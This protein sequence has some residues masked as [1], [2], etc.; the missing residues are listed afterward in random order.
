MNAFSNLA[1]LIS[2]KVLFLIIAFIIIIVLYTAIR[3][4]E[5]ALVGDAVQL[6]LGDPA[7]KLVGDAVGLL[8]V[9]LVGDAVQLALGDRVGKLMGDSVGLLEWGR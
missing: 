7:E 9:A 4:L 2:E 6:A 5:G 1:I 8:V 3:L